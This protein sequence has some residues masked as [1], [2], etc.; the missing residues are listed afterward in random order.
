MYYLT[1]KTAFQ[2]DLKSKTSCISQIYTFLSKKEIG[3]V[4]IKFYQKLLILFI[5]LSTFLIVS[6]SPREFE[7]ICEVYNSKESCNVW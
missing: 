7:N 2:T 6:E 3:L 4:S 1:M 5:S